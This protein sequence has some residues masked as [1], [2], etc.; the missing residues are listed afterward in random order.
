MYLV[1]GG[2]GFIGCNLVK[3]LNQRGHRDVIIVDH[4]NNEQKK[5]DLAM[6][7]Y[8]EYIDKYTFLYRISLGYY[9]NLFITAIF[10]N[11]A[12][13]DTRNI[14]VEYMNHNNVLFSKCLL[15]FASSRQI[16]FLYASSASVYGGGHNGFR[17][18]LECE[19]PLNVYA[20]TKLEF[21]QYARKMIVNTKSQ[22]VG[23]RY[24]N[25]FGRNESH[26]LNM[27]S[28]IYQ[29]CTEILEFNRITIFNSD[30]CTNGDQRRDF[31]HV[32]DIVKINLFFLDHPELSGLFNCGTGIATSFRDIAESIMEI[33]GG[34]QLQYKALPENMQHTY[35]NFT[36]AD[37]TGLRMVNYPCDFVDFRTSLQE[38][39]E[40]I[41]ASI[42]KKTGGDTVWQ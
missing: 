40:L 32:D 22:V 5:E 13:S 16:P 41:K 20:K 6:L 12:C 23:L 15:D 39:Y 11:G 26:K 38:Y 8:A 24:F 2:A 25:V 19:F 29:F 37:L 10:H 4:L 17:E 21:D 7:D 1:T 31:I 34:G 30:Q 42:I 35:Q 36:E 3:A 9:D 27:A 33:H 18:E 28:V 14:D